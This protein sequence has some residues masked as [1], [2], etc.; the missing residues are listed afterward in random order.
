[1]IMG[2]DAKDVS[3]FTFVCFSCGSIIDRADKK[4]SL[5]FRG[6]KLSVF[7]LAVPA[8]GANALRAL[9]DATIS[10]TIMVSGAILHV[11]ISPFL[12]FGLAG[13]PELGLSGAAWA[14]LLARFITFSATILI[15]HFREA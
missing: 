5:R 6:T 15:L 12:I 4:A 9:G 8:V 3:I 1:M 7:F 2:S 10:G 13:L 14:N 11:A